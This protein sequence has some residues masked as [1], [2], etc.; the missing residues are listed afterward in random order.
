[1]RPDEEFEPMMKVQ[2]LG[3]QEVKITLARPN[4]NGGYTPTIERII[5]PGVTEYIATPKS[6]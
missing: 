2:N 3:D 5:A 6:T 4:G 1:M